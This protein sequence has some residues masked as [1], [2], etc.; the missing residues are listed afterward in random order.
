LIPRR[1]LTTTA[2]GILEDTSPERYKAYQRPIIRTLTETPLH[3]LEMPRQTGK[4]EDMAR[5]GAAYLCLNIDVQCF[6]PTLRQGHELLLTDIA[7]VMKSLGVGLPKFNVYGLQCEHGAR[8]HVGSTNEQ[9]SGAE[10]YTIGCTLLDEAHRAEPH[11]I[12]TLLPSMKVMIEQGFH[13]FIAAGVRGPRTSLIE[14]AWRERGFKLTKITPE[15]VLAKDPLYQVALDTFKATLSDDEYR[16]YI[17]L[18]EESG[19]RAIF[20]HIGAIDP[21][22]IGKPHHDVIGIDTGQMQDNTVITQLRYYP[23]SMTPQLEIIKTWQMSDRYD[24]QLQKIKDLIYENEFQTIPIGVETQ[25]GSGRAI[26]DF[27]SAP[28]KY[29]EDPIREVYACPVSNRFKKNMI[30]WLEVFDKGDRSNKNDPGGHLNC[31]D[32]NMLNALDGLERERNDAGLVTFTHSD[33]LSSLIVAAAMVGY[34]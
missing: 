13:S 7:N 20:H 2:L 30:D 14:T 18:T 8:V 22:W 33:Y 25:D 9:Y 21:I 24:V 31:R 5:I 19:N 27:L 23:A 11:W 16:K 17:E 12:G 10:G 29:N 32:E 6:Y 3:V 1:L 15:D 28:D 26:H 4:T 34:G